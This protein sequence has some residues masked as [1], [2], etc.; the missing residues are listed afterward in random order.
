[1]STTSQRDSRAY[2]KA[3]QRAK[4]RSGMITLAVQDIPASPPVAN[5][6]RR[7]RADGDFKF[8][9]RHIAEG[10]QWTNVQAPGRTVR[11]WSPSPASPTTTG[12]TALWAAP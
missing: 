7:A 5:P 9:A 12:S 1:M 10:Q 11:E 8:F 4:A 2:Q 6:A 3:H